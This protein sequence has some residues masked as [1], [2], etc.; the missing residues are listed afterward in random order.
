MLLKCVN[1]DT[2]LITIWQF[3]KIDYCKLFTSTSLGNRAAASGSVFSSA[4]S[5]PF[6][7]FMSNVLCFSFFL[8][9]SFQMLLFVVDSKYSWSECLFLFAHLS[10]GNTHQRLCSCIVMFA[11][12]KTTSCL[13]N[14][15]QILLVVRQ[16]RFPRGTLSLLVINSTL[17]CIQY[18]HHSHYN[19]D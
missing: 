7:I 19:D 11:Y 6:C 8:W 4:C 2:V 3:V 12:C 16:I 15:L 10:A 13:E 17:Q 18:V 1:A 5:A 9:E 14:V